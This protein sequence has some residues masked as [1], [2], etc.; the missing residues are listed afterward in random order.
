[1][2]EKMEKEVQ[3]CA[4]L[5]TKQSLAADIVESVQQPLVLVQDV[6]LLHLLNNFLVDNRR[7]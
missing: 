6:G 1:M 5:A 7:H 2:V 4:Q 3:S